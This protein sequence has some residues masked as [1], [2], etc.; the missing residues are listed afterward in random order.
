LSQEDKEWQNK[1]DIEIIVNND[2][3]SRKTLLPVLF[4]LMLCFLY[5]GVS[6]PWLQLSVLMAL[7]FFGAG[8]VVAVIKQGW[9]SPRRWY[10]WLACSL[11]F[12][13]AAA[14]HYTGGIA[15]FVFP[16]YSTIMV[17]VAL[18]LPG[19]QVAV[20]LLIAILTYL[21]EWFGEVAGLLPRFIIFPELLPSTSLAASPYIWV[22]PLA[23]VFSLCAI[24]YLTYQVSF[25]LKERREELL[26]LN[27]RL[28][29]EEQL[30][31]RQ[32]AENLSLREETKRKIAELERLKGHLEESVRERTASLM[33]KVIELDRA[34]QQYREKNSE[35]SEMQELIT[36]RE[37]TVERLKAELNCLRQE[38]GELPKS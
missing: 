26:A 10:F 32:A 16:I 29:G 24:A 27:K 36:G 20:V 17:I 15:S 4:L 35:I 23:N 38:L 6:Y 9:G 18:T 28:R 25:L 7:Y 37:K 14:M 13:C 21:A 2:N 1:Q 11:N 30:A 19:W 12:F 33:D 8:T 31:R 34:A 22:T 3:V 5:L